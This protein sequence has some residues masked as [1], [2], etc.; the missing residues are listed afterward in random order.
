VG[1]YL[2]HWIKNVVAARVRPST[3][4]FYERVIAPARASVGGVALRSLT[5]MHIQAMLGR[6]DEEGV[7]GRGRQ[8]AFGALR[9]ALRDAVKSKLLAANPADAV[10]RPRAPKKEIQALDADQVR[11]LLAVAKG[12]PLEALYALAIGTGLR[13]GELCG[14]RWGDFDLE[15]GVVRV[16]RAL[17]ERVNGERT[18]A[19]PKTSRGRRQVDIPAFAIAAVLRHR[20]NLGGAIPHPATLVFPAPEG[21]FMRRS[22]LKR[23]S[24]HPLLD[25]AKLKRVSFHALR[26]SAAT[27]QLA[28]GV[29][30]RVVQERLG[31]STVQ[32]TLDTYSHVLPTLGKD[33]AARIDALV[34]G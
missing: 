15:A 22:N 32:L 10:T 11:A 16:Q 14:L 19:E 2:D 18:L 23:R 3:L 24:Y 7:S 20:A 27:L 31:H 17:V 6:L 1:A 9:T 21:G 25:R 26:H 29:N 4:D 13:L 28:A 33:A 5:P 34:G 12:D 8:Q 30:P